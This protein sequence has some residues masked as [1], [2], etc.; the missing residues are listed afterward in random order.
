MLVRFQSAVTVVQLVSSGPVPAI[1]I[2]SVSLRAGNEA[3]YGQ[4]VSCTIYSV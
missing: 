4:L 1:L 3:L 2:S